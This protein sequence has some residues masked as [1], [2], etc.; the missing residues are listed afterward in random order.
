ME[1]AQRFVGRGCR[2]KVQAD[3]VT[4]RGFAS[5]ASPV[6]TLSTSY[7]YHTW[8][9]EGQDVDTCYQAGIMAIPGRHTK[10]RTW[11]ELPS[12][13]T[14]DE[15]HASLFTAQ[16]RQPDTSAGAEDFLQSTPVMRT[17]DTL[18]TLWTSRGLFRTRQRDFRLAQVPRQNHH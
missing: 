5:A 4:S 13:P 17:V 7:G 1:R 12:N 2:R 15:R 9:N 18:S 8:L 14:C 6:I 10:H 3:R 11:L 16:T